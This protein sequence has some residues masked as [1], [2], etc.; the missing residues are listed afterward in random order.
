VS[1]LD[2]TGVGV[3]E[4]QRVV[5]KEDQ[6]IHVHMSGWLGKACHAHLARTVK[7]MSSSRQ[8]RRSVCEL[9]VRCWCWS[10]VGDATGLLVVLRP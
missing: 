10:S 2:A 8:Q 9:V 3:G 5:H 1:V 4:R 6:S 7:D